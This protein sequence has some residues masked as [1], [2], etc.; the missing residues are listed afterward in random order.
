MRYMLIQYVRK[1]DGGMDEVMKVTRNLKKNDVRTHQ[2]ILDFAKMQVLQAS[3]NGV[4][5]PRDW[6][7]IV[8]YYHQHYKATI[9]RMLVEN[10]LVM[11][12]EDPNEEPT[13][14]PS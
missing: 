3:L 14:N 12:K 13:N 8:G 7:R 5:V 6:N 4:Q 9:D 10:N 11:V 2:V 1:P